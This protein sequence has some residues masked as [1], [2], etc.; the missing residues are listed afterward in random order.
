MIFL[1]AGAWLNLVDQNQN[2]QEMQKAKAFML[3]LSEPLCTSD[4]IIA[5]TYK[6]LIYHNRPFTQSKKVLQSALLQELAIVLSIEQ[7]DRKLAVNILQ[8]YKDQKLSYEDAITVSLAYRYGI[9]KIFSF[10]RHFLLFP[11]LERVPH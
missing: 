9:K 4:L 8:K 11:G 10:D 5:E 7:E 6:W 2:F 3:S 1:D